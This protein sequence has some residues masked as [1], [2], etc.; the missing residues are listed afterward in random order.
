MAGANPRLN[1][2]VIRPEFWRPDHAQGLS[3]LVHEAYHNWQR[4]L[5]PDFDARYTSMVAQARQQG[6]P[7]W[8]TPLEKAAYQVEQEAYHWLVAQGW[9]A[10]VAVPHQEVTGHWEQVLLAEGGPETLADLERLDAFYDEGDLGE[11]QLYLQVDLPDSYEADVRRSLDELESQLRL[12][13]AEPWPGEPRISSLDW[14]NKTVFLRFRQAAPFLLALGA[15]LVALATIALGLALVLRSLD[16]VGVPV[17]EAVLDVA[18]AVFLLAAIIAGIILLRRVPFVGRFL[19]LGA[20][21]GGGLL[22]FVLLAPDLAV[23][24]FKWAWREVVLPVLRRVGEELV[25]RVGPVLGLLALALGGL[26]VFQALPR[27][28]ER[29]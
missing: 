28:R 19:P 29:S 13:G 25:E 17:P 14:P 10:A 23:R 1:L 5:L 7:A 15:L 16:A 11:V 18:D 24:L 21:V 4:Q 12:R 26:L 2:V 20:L 3:L 9:P 8:D 6:L 27:E 22:I